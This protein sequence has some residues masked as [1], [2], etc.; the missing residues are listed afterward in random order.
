MLK[1]RICAPPDPGSRQRG[2]ATVGASDAHDCTGVERHRGCEQ[3]LSPPD[4]HN[5]KFGDL[6][7][8]TNTIDSFEIKPGA[9]QPIPVVPAGST[10]PQ[11]SGFCF[12]LREPNVWLCQSGFLLPRLGAH[13]TRGGQ[14]QGRGLMDFNR[15][16][17]FQGAIDGGFGDYDSAGGL[18]DATFPPTPTGGKPRS[19]WE[20]TIRT[21]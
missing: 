1:H 9:T 12:L 21:P 11:V 19:R 10:E 16:E 15:P 3:G 4:P 2:P 6:V 8:F 18:I 7:V 13:F 17:P 5:K 14:I 20:M